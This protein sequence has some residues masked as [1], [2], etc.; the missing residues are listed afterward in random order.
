MGT[1]TATIRT[2]GH[3]P[4]KKALQAG[5][6]YLKSK[7]LGNTI[8]HSMATQWIYLG[9]NGGAEKTTKYS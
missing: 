6:E 3:I 9:L 8:L 2:L 1:F 5:I 7:A 4:K